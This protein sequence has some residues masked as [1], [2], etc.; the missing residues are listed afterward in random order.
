MP[1]SNPSAIKLNPASTNGVLATR[2]YQKGWLKGGRLAFCSARIPGYKEACQKGPRFAS[3]FVTTVYN[4]LCLQY[5]WHLELDEEPTEGLAPPPLDHELT[6]EQ[7][8]LK[9]ARL[10]CLLKGV[11]NWFERQSSKAAPIAKM[12]KAQIA[13]DPVAAFLARTSKLG[14]ERLRA[15]TFNNEFALSGLDPSRARIKAIAGDTQAKWEDLTTTKKAFWQD[16]AEKDKEETKKGKE[17]A[18]LPPT[19]LE[20]EQAQIAMDNMANT[21]TPLLDGLAMI[22]GGICTFTFAGPEPRK[23]GQINVLTLHSGKNKAPAPKAFFEADGDRGKRRFKTFE[24]A[25]GEFALTCFSP[26]EQQAR[27]LPGSLMP[28]AQ[29]W[30]ANQEHHPWDEKFVASPTTVGTT[31]TSTGTTSRYMFSYL[32][33]VP[34]LLTSAYRHPCRVFSNT[35]ESYPD[36]GQSSAYAI[37]AILVIAHSSRVSETIRV[38]PSHRSR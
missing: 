23:G 13:K 38:H 19:L 32:T 16:L 22:L 24:A 15:H 28:R 34:V 6:P 27:A 25:I 31:S 18:R 21:I 37:V 33:N 5:P 12:S 30:F 3:D 10:D 36:R 11:T 20:P 14:P 35:N 29:P 7:R 8:Q 26:E 1:K 4:E 2:F 17:Q 9:A